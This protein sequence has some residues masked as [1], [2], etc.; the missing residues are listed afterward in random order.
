[1]RCYKHKARWTYDERDIRAADRTFAELDLD[2]DDAV[3]VQLPA[4]R[5][6]PERD[7]EEWHRPDWARADFDAG[8]VNRARRWTSLVIVAHP[9]LRLTREAAADLRRPWEKPPRPVSVEGFGTSAHTCTVRR[10]HRNPQHPAQEGHLGPRIAAPRPATTSGRR[11][12][13][14]RASSSG[15]ASEGKRQAKDPSYRRGQQPVSRTHS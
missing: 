12:D 11:P 9:Q 13:D 14:L 2:L 10:V 1:M 5:D 15:T 7:P 6:A 3:D 4:Y 8:R